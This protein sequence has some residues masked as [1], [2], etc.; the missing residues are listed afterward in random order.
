M[1]KKKVRY[2][3][4]EFME[5]A[6]RAEGT[7]DASSTGVP[8]K[9][10]CD[11][12]PTKLN[13][14][15]N[16]HFY[17][18]KIVS[19]RAVIQRVS[20]AKVEIDSETR[21]EIGPGLLVLLGVTHSDTQTDI[22]WLIRKLCKLRIFTDEA[23]KMNHSIVDVGGGML[24]VSQ[25]TLYA[26]SKKGNRP[27][28]IRSAPPEIAVPLYEQ[29]FDELAESV[30]RTGRHGR[31]WC[32][33]GCEPVQRRPGHDYIG[34]TATGFLSSLIHISKR[35]RLSRW[36]DTRGA[37]GKILVLALLLRTVLAFLLRGVPLEG[38]AWEYFLMAGDMAEGKPFQ[39]YWPP[40][41]PLYE[42]IYIFFFGASQFVVR[43]AMLFW[44]WL[45][46]RWSSD[47]LLRLHS[48]RAANI[49]LIFLGFYPAFVYQKRR[50]FELFASGSLAAGL[51]QL[52]AALRRRKALEL[53]VSHRFFPRLARV[54]SAFRPGFLSW[55]Y[56]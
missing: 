42:A 30:F 2:E 51:L 11:G 6:N 46:C 47:L 16:C 31:V 3:A 20:H 29:F 15:L 54:V 48:R 9:S 21:G 19:M 26:N 39:V 17:R 43:L 34:H 18:V 1:P 44:F 14:S 12:I 10:I 52:C 28:Y 45:L 7:R 4:N 56:R 5:N 32:D 49:A 41:L 25:F 24:V 22:D 53:P 33:D 37:G 36:L 35:E 55:S 13:L 23:G 27:S 8:K 50:A 38:D 40:G